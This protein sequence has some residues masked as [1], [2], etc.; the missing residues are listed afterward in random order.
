M[1]GSSVVLLRLVVWLSGG[2][3]NGGGRRKEA[4]E[5]RVVVGGKVPGWWLYRGEGVGEARPVAGGVG[6][7]VARRRKWRGALAIKVTAT[8]A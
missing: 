5:S 8:R 1:I 3:R 2:R 6:N 4:M 7:G